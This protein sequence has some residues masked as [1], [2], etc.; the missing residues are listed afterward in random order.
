MRVKFHPGQ[1]VVT[2]AAHELLSEEQMFA[3]LT[4]HLSGDWGELC[5]EDKRANEDA[6]KYGNRILSR[7]MVNDE[8]FYVITEHDRSVTTILRVSDY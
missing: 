4:F 5:A 7:Y 2:A 3:M 1:T 6:L 8:P